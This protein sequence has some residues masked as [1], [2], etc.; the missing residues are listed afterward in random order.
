MTTFA[1]MFPRMAAGA[2]ALLEGDPLWPDRSDLIVCMNQ[3]PDAVIDGHRLHLRDHVRVCHASTKD[4]GKCSEAAL[5]ISQNL[6]YLFY[7]AAGIDGDHFP[8]SHPLD[9][10]AVRALERRTSGE[11]KVVKRTSPEGV[12]EGTGEKADGGTHRQTRQIGEE[13]GERDREETGYEDVDAEQFLSPLFC[14]PAPYFRQYFRPASVAL[15]R[16]GGLSSSAPNESSDVPPLP[17]D[18]VDQPLY[19]VLPGIQP[20]QIDWNVVH[21][22]GLTGLMRILV[23]IDSRRR[24]NLRRAVDHN[25]LIDLARSWDMDITLERPKMCQLLRECWRKI[26]I[27][28]TFEDP[29]TGIHACWFSP[30]QV[31]GYT[32]DE[33][34]PL[35]ERLCVSRLIPEPLP[36]SPDAPFESSFPA[37]DIRNP[38]PCPPAPL[39]SFE[40]GALVSSDMPL[41]SFLPPLPSL[42]SL[43]SSSTMTTTTTTTMAMVAEM[44]VTEVAMVVEATAAEAAMEVEMDAGKTIATATANTVDRESDATPIAVHKMKRKREDEEVILPRKSRPDFRGASPSGSG[45]DKDALSIGEPPTDDWTMA[46]FEDRARRFM[47]TSELDS[48]S[49]LL[50]LPKIDSVENWVKEYVLCVFSSDRSPQPFLQRMWLSEKA[51]PCYKGG[52]GALDRFTQRQQQVCEIVRTIAQRAGC[53]A[54]GSSSPYPR[55]MPSSLAKQAWELLKSDSRW[56]DRSDLI[57]CL[58]LVSP[59]LLGVEQDGPDL[60]EHLRE[61]YDKYCAHWSVALRLLHRCLPYLILSPSELAAK[62]DD[63]DASTQGSDGLL[64]PE[65]HKKNEKEK[66]QREYEEDEEDKEEEE[67]EEESKGDEEDE[68]DEEEEEEEGEQNQRTRGARW[69]RGSSRLIEEEERLWD[70]GDKEKGKSEEEKEVDKRVEKTRV[71]IFYGPA[72]YFERYFWFQRMQEMGQ[73]QSTYNL[74]NGVP[75]CPSDLED[76][77]LYLILPGINLAKICWARLQYHKLKHLTRLML[78]IASLKEIELPRFIDRLALVDLA[79]SWGEDL[80]VETHKMCQ[81]LLQCRHHI[82]VSSLSNTTFLPPGS[83]SGSDRKGEPDSRQQRRC[84]WL[85]PV[86]IPGFTYDQPHPTIRMDDTDLIPRESPYHQKQNRRPYVST[87]L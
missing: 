66:G 69:N 44:M 82:L 72:P 70:Q 17:R 67:E 80:L 26:F 86:C 27:R 85:S 50:L 35:S 38:M 29:E 15:C 9:L 63:G 87:R 3:L 62:R 58:G 60:P 12:V 28:C 13:E 75:P 2:R 47:A 20:E 43:S 49:P 74:D 8:M 77:S 22:P 53:I 57:A 78:Y 25:V 55:W 10:D 68:E 41:P 73:D 54:L 14:G 42:S 83:G 45:G 37:V 52:M 40:P 34:E 46:L 30:V 48:D 33:P 18:V 56:A 59:T 21:D 7:P 81:L 65:A 23:T 24:M 1:R 6:A 19:E 36:L 11:V 84:Y 39:C 76:R 16:G 61:C 5:L 4:C 71:P 32:R 51:L 64:E 79:T 31:P